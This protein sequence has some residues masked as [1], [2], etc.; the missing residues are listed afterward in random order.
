MTES[1]FT[2]CMTMLAGGDMQGLKQVYEEYG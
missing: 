2:S 1:N